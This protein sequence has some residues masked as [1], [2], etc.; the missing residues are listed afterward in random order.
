VSDRATPVF[1]RRAIGWIA[2]LAAGSFVLAIVFG[3][4]AGELGRPESAGA[5]AFSRS[6]IGHGAL[7]ELLPALGI[8]VSL[9][10]RSGPPDV[11]PERP[12]LLLEPREPPLAPF[13]EAVRPAF[14]DLRDRALHRGAATVVALP[15]RHA[16]PSA[17]RPGWLGSAEVRGVEPAWR[18][19]R[20][21]AGED[22]DLELALRE[23]RRFSCET[24]WGETVAVE[25]PMLQALAPTD[26]AEPLVHCGDEGWIVARLAGDGPPTVLVTD[27]DVLANF[28]LGRGENARVV[29]GLLARGLGATSVVIDETIHGF[30]VE[31]GILREL[32]RP[33]LVLAVA[34]AVV[35]LGF[36][37]WSGGRRFGSPVPVAER[38]EGG[39]EIL[40]D[41]TAQMM[42]LAGPPAG[43]LHDYFRQTLRAVAAH[44]AVPRTL[45]DGELARRLAP[46][47]VARGVRPDPLALAGRVERAVRHGSLTGA[48]AVV[49]A[50]A[51]HRFREAMTDV[52]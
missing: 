2:G 1:S 46:I 25:V 12:L 31:G 47:A 52:A 11:G 32:L 13:G 22:A 14:V 17:F 7:V 48:R 49:L 27:P 34:H 39:K 15:K 3:A 41:N 26:A 5:D 50:R 36:V 9:R 30:G 45:A 18:V 38:A 20:A 43:V 40:I 16:V 29:Y 28:G 8:E 37:V 42:E 10:R 21:L 23:G 24:E 19:A 4:F 33:P 51:I 6:A 44:H 35:V